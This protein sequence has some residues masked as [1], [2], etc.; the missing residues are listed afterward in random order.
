MALVVVEHIDRGVGLA[1]A[2]EV[3][4]GDFASVSLDQATITGGAFGDASQSSVI[5]NASRMDLEE[6]FIADLGPSTSNLRLLA[7]NPDFDVD[8]GAGQSRAVAQKEVAASS[9]TADAARG[10][11]I[12]LDGETP[13]R[14]ATRSNIQELL[15]DG[16]EALGLNGASVGKSPSSSRQY[17][18]NPFTQSSIAYDPQLVPQVAHELKVLRD[19]SVEKEQRRAPTP[20]MSLAA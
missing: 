6:A 13:A 12:V 8:Q 16:L 1:R 10:L 19:E 9:I 7:Q 17:R 11:A 15:A 3:R 2:Q 4:L 20:S 14:D 5:T 18:G